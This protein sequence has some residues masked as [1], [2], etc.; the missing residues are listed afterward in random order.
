MS[1]VLN[2]EYSKLIISLT[3]LNIFN[4]SFQKFNFYYIILKFAKLNFM[5]SAVSSMT[6]HEMCVER[7]REGR[8][9]VRGNQ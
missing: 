5:F 6:Q 7:R 8:V 1:K 9:F 2:F 3:F 4:L